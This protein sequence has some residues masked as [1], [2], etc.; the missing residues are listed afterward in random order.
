MNVTAYALEHGP[1]YE[2]RLLACQVLFVR[3]L[4]NHAPR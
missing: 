1:H 2:P 3:L 4:L